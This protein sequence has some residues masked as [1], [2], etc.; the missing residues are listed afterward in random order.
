MPDSNKTEWLDRQLHNPYRPPFEDLATLSTNSSFRQGRKSLE[1]IIANCFH[2]YFITTVIAIP[3]VLL[4][5]VSF[6]ASIVSV[7]VI[8]YLIYLRN[9]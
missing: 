5:Y 7:I 1:N 6:A 2:A 9:R 3:V 4:W 8:S